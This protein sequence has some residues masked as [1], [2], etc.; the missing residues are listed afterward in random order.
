MEKWVSMDSHWR[1]DE[2]DVFDDYRCADD[3]LHCRST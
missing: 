1:S 2:L 3:V